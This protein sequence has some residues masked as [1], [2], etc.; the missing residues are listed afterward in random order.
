MAGQASIAP[1]RHRLHPLQRLPL[2]FSAIWS[3]VNQPC[4]KSEWLPVKFQLY[5]RSNDNGG[6]LR[7]QPKALSIFAVLSFVLWLSPQLAVANTV[8]TYIGNP[9]TSILNGEVFV[10]IP[11]TTS[12][13]V[14]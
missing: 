1:S 3:G 4:C 14:T 5:W 12:D 2:N 9:F 13:F 8:Y 10:P 6:L 11:F 7:L